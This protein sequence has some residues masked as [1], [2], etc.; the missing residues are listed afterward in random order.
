MPD[1]LRDKIWKVI[2]D[3]DDV[4]AN[5]YRRFVEGKDIIAA[6]KLI[7]LH[8]QSEQAPNPDSRVT[9]SDERDALG[10]NW[11]RLEWRLTELDKRSVEVMTKAIGAEFGRL[12]LGRVRLDDWLLDGGKDWGPD[13]KGSPH[14]MGTTR[15]SDDPRMGVVDRRCRVHGIE[16]LYIAG[17][18]V[19]PTGGYM[20]PTLT[21]VALAL[22]L[23]DHLEAR[24]A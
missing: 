16:N 11:A 20:N 10:L 18:S 24:F 17:S 6:P 21:I 3:L 14:H 7:Y 19:F 12:N 1:D 8:S 5:V 4:A 9:L 23:A 22:R 13:L 2:L 15:M